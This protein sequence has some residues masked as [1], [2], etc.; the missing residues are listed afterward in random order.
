MLSIIFAAS[1]ILVENGSPTAAFEPVETNAVSDVA[2]FNSRLKEVTGVSLGV[3]GEAANRIRVKLVEPADIAHRFGWKIRFPDERC[4]EIVATRRSLMAALVSILEESCDA[5]FLGSERC[6]FQFEPRKSASVEVRDR[7]SAPHCYTLNRDVFHVP[8]NRRELG[9]AEDG[10]FRYTHGIPVYAFPK[11]KYDREGWPEAIMPTLKNGRKLVKAPERA[12]VGWQP[13][14]SSPEAGRIAA[15]NVL[16]YLRAHPGET[17]I[18][19]GVNDMRGY[20]ECSRCHEM[21]DGGEPAIFTNN[22]MTRSASYYTFVNT[23]AKAVASEFPAVRIGLLAY[24]GTIMPPPFDVSPNVVPM[25]TFDLCAAAPDPDVVAKQEDVIR[26]WGEKVRETGTWSYEWG[27]G[28]MMPRVDFAAQAHRLRFLWE[29]GGRAYFGEAML[30]ALEGPKLYLISK[31]LADVDLD[32]KALLDE[33]FGRYAGK[34]AEAPLREL[35]RRVAEYGRSPRMKRTAFWRQRG[36][37]Y[38]QPNASRQMAQLAALEPG[39][40]HGLVELAERVC[41]A[42]STPGERRRAE[43]LLRHFE[44]LDVY[45]AFLGYAH[46]RP[47]TCRPDDAE[48]AA[49]MLD[50]LARRAKELI[51]EF[52][53]AKAYFLDPDFYNPD[54]Y[55]GRYVPLDMR[56]LLV[57]QLTSAGAWYADRRVSAAFARLAKCD[58]LP[59]ELRDIV[60]SVSAAFSNPANVFCNPG[61][62][63]PLDEMRVKTA[64]PHEIA[65][66]FKCAGGRMVCIRPGDPVGGDANPY[67]HALKDVAAFHFEQDV[68]P[69]YYSA[70]VRVWTDASGPRSADLVL[71]RQA[72]GSAR[73]WEGFRPVGLPSGR[74]RTL[75][76]SCKVG[77]SVDGVRF[78][79]RLK[80]FKPGEKVYL[81]DVRLQK[82]APVP[83]ERRGVVFGGSLM[84]VGRTSRAIERDDGV[85][86][87]IAVCRTSPAG[88]AAFARANISA[89]DPIE[90]KKGER[91]VV[92]VRC[93]SLDEAN[94]AVI[95]GKVSEKVNGAYGGR[96]NA[97]FWT[98]RIPSAWTDVAGHIDESSLS[99]AA[100]RH[101]LLVNLFQLK[102]SGPVAVMSVSWK[103]VGAKEQQG[104]NAMKREITL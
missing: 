35:Y 75:H 18:T 19:L 58:A 56:P 95:G 54:H 90:V 4:M 50:E 33:W 40:A 69:G 41:A 15:E 67:D 5:R 71:W 52:D 39:F 53:R 25:M 68:P 3:G 86:R 47:E 77:A 7:R 51:G 55:R 99:D 29:N 60:S 14:Y 81:G 65:G 57:E 2:L 64:L 1:F 45:A 44:I 104:D 37:I 91:L 26:R 63:N 34:A 8:G 85:R 32:P 13:C 24:T 11:A 46:C 93:R 96:G 38:V 62:A 23:V 84:L 79:L 80:G 30:D 103:V 73:D 9:L 97:L 70:S 27:R 48:S 101:R 61:F 102:D 92:T 42:A 100:S 88:P 21:D 36:Y 17:S 78:G 87:S 6:M 16:G 74:W 10:K 43:V 49:A 12:L 22:G 31:L 59:A 94:P 98:R 76:A 89:N 66:S 28:Y 83:D 72:G 82:I 20:C